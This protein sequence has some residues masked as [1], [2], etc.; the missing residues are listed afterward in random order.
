MVNSLPRCISRSGSPPPG[1]SA[2]SISF[3]GITGGSPARHSHMP[4]DSRA[5]VVADDDE[6]V[7]FRLQADG[8][9]DRGAELLVAGGGPQRLA[10]IRGVL[11]AESRVQ[12]A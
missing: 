1:T 3:Q 2:M 4:A 7:T 11:V 12:C 9:V 8:A 5:V 6:V 10:Q